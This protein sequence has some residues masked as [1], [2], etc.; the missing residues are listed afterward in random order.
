MSSLAEF[1][2]SMKRAILGDANAKALA[3]ADIV[4][5]GL[6]AEQRIQ[7]H[8]NNYR[9]TLTDSLKATFPI[10]QAFVGEAFFE[11]AL[12]KF[13]LDMPPRWAQLSKY[14]EAL[15][16]F[17]ATYEHAE[18]IPYITD[19]VR[20]EWAVHNIQNSDAD[21]TISADDIEDLI[22][23]GSLIK[24]VKQIEIVES[25]YPVLSLWMVGT[26]QMPP[27]AVHLDQ[28]GQIALVIGG[29]GTVQLQ[30]LEEKQIDILVA[31]DAAETSEA[32][33]YE[34]LLEDLKQMATRG[35]LKRADI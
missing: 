4:S 23:Q 18:T 25:A 8:E 26:G 1:Q 20:L 19:L 9:E 3:A 14:G 10:S 12:R 11:G 6:A 35:M 7:I 28:G 33:N 5:D 22:A 17:F 27:E 13:V 2:R 31:L 24:P 34:G 29:E 30:A 21:N 16:D 15:A 32:V